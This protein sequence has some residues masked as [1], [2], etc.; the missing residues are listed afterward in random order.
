MPIVFSSSIERYVYTISRSFLLRSKEINSKIALRGVETLRI[1][2]YLL[3]SFLSSTIKEP[4]NS[5]SLNLTWNFTHI[6]SKLVFTWKGSIKKIQGTFVR[7]Q[8]YSNLVSRCEI[9]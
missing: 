4:T 1:F 6:S 7:S 8:L 3:L 5:C 2:N 9:L